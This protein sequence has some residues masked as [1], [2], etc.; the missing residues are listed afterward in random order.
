[1]RGGLRLSAAQLAN[2]PA[3]G[4][5]VTESQSHWRGKLADHFGVSRSRVA[6]LAAE[7]VS[8]N[9]RTEQNEKLEQYI[10]ET[11]VDCTIRFSWEHRFPLAR[12]FVPGIPQTLTIGRFSK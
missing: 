5:H 3:R 6:E 9:P 10:L 11:E 1:M 12:L 7:L 8:G 4:A 2:V